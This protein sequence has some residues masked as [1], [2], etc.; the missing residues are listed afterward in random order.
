MVLNKLTLEMQ[1]WIQMK[2]SIIKE[3]GLKHY[4][5]H[6]MLMTNFID[7]IYK[8]YSWVK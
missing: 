2:V 1:L 3:T 4:D 7:T 6:M 8:I 5:V